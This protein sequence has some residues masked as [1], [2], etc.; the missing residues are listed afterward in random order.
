M[1]ELAGDLERWSGGGPV[2]AQRCF[3][4]RKALWVAR[5][6]A[7]V[8]AAASLLAVLWG[9]W[10]QEIPRCVPSAGWYRNTR[11]V[12][13]PALVEVPLEAIWPNPNYSGF[14]ITRTSML[15]DL[16]DWRPIPA[17]A[18]PE[19]AG[20]VEPVH[21]TRI[22]DVIRKRS[23]QENTTISFQ[24][25]TEGA[26]VDF[27]CR[28]HPYVVKGATKR[29]YLGG[30]VKKSLLIRQIDVDLSREAVDKEIR[31]VLHY[32]VW[33]GFQVR[34]DGKQWAAALAPDDLPMMELAVQFP[35]ALMPPKNPRLTYFPRVD[36]EAI[37]AAAVWA[38]SSP[39]FSVA[40]CTL[41]PWVAQT[42]PTAENHVDPNEAPIFRRGDP[43]RGEYWWV[44]RPLDV[45]KD[46]VY[47]MTWD[48]SPAKKS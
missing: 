10:R 48:W 2:R 14:R 37:T 11:E 12:P 26:E 20:R 41:A 15:W 27:A 18:R 24:Y 21:I 34:C 44:W 39:R 38:W 19:T 1:D 5:W 29:A 45:R 3:G 47:K 17:N 13:P 31:I 28:S 42:T 7:A 30:E 4:L 40:D 9:W 6:P 22:V 16:R 23:R 46:H 25:R 32:T 33:N 36:R 8:T 35:A 43:R